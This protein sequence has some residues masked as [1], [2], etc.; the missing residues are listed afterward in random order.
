LTT[1]GIGLSLVPALLFVTYLVVKEFAVGN[2]ANGFSDDWF[3]RLRHMDAQPLDRLT[4][5]WDTLPADRRDGDLSNPEVQRQLASKP[6]QLAE[7]EQLIGKKFAFGD[8]GQKGPWAVFQENDLV[9]FV[10]GL[11]EQAKIES[12]GVRTWNY[13]GGANGGYHVEQA[14]QITS[15]EGTFE[16][17]LT[18]ES[19]QTKDG[20]RQWQ[21][22]LPNTGLM[23]PTGRSFTPAGKFLIELRGESAAFARDWA[24]LVAQKKLQEAYLQTLPS[25]ARRQAETLTNAQPFAN[26]WNVYSA[27]GRQDLT[28]ALVGL[29]LLTREDALARCFL[30]AYEPFTKGKLIT[31]PPLAHK[32]GFGEAVL[33]DA[34]RAFAGGDGP[35]P[36]VGEPA[37]WLGI[38][39]HLVNDEIVI[40]HR[41]TFQRQ[42]YSCEGILRVAT[43]DPSVVAAVKN[44]AG[45]T[46]APRSDRWRVVNIQPRFAAPAARGGPGG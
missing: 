12:R 1:W 8:L 44:G 19:F 18:A 24:G 14:Y 38:R 22:V 46:L 25:A 27:T 23:P 32:A 43:D 17:V 40:D 26:V 45:G 4:T 9:K 15:P 13:H 11:P 20:S 37:N 39:W 31:N 34:K 35:V 7:V 41:F 3:T 28:T 2:E 29:S 36:V 16:V 30:P 21:V 42:Q 33:G 10:Q 5:F 6:D